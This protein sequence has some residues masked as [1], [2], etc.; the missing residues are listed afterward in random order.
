LLSTFLRHVLEYGMR[1]DE[2]PIGYWLRELDRR[3][4]DAFAAALTRHD[5]QRRDWQVLNGLGPEDPFWAEGERPYSAVIA[6][7]TAR[8]WTDT[9]GALTPAGEAARAEIA[10]EV[11]LVRR[12]AVTG[13]SD[14]D[15]RTTIRTLATM[16]GN[17]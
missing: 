5:V 1:P 12:R 8:G 2:R 15:Y 13:L 11:A 16:A 14:E 3:L 6:D 17:L 7:L 4:E 10:A 9:S